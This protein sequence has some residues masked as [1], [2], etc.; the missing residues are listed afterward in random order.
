[1]SCGGKY[2]TAWSK[3]QL[4]IKTVMTNTVAYTAE[5]C[6]KPIKGVTRRKD[7]L[8]LNIILKLLLLPIVLIIIRQLERYQ[9]N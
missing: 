8:F 1:M 2:V 6:Y 5:S 4:V 9:F 7:I 3:I